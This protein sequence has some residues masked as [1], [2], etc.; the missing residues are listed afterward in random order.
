MCLSWGKQGGRKGGR[1]DGD[2]HDAYF[3]V[4]TCQKCWIISSPCF[5]SSLPPTRT[6]LKGFDGHGKRRRE[7]ADLAVGHTMG[8]EA[9]EDGLGTGREGKR[10]A[11][12][13]REDGRHR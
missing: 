2:H 13:E 4:N 12:S 7:K 1:E 10:E 11:G 8:Q 9:F 3:T 6:D 5:S